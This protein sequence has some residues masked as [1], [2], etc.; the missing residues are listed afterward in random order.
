MA[1]AIATT[2]FGL[3]LGTALRGVD[4]FL[5]IPYADS[6]R[7]FEDPVVWTAPFVNGTRAATS[8]ASICMQP[9]DQSEASWIGSED[10]LFL[11]I[12]RPSNA[13]GLPVMLWIHGGSFLVG[14]GR[15]YNA[16]TLASKH[17]A[18]YVT[19][20]YRLAAFGFAQYAAGHGNYGLKDQ[21]TAMSWVN[22]HIASFGG[23][24]SKV[25]VFGESAGAMSLA[26]H[27]LSPASAGLFAG[28]LMQSG[29]AAA[30]FQ[31]TAVTNAA[32]FAALCG[33]TNQ[34]NRQALRTCLQRAPL[35]V[36]CNASTL[37]SDAGAPLWAPGGAFMWG[38]SVDAAFVPDLPQQMLR[39]G[40]VPIGSTARLIAGVNTD[41]G[42]T[43]T[44]TQLPDAPLD[45]PAYLAILRQI[46][47]NLQASRVDGGPPLPPD[48][49]VVR[50]AVALYPPARGDEPS[51]NRPVLSAL[52]T[53]LTFHCS[54]RHL[55]HALSTFG[56]N[57][58]ENVWLYRFNVRCT[59]PAPLLALPPSCL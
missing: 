48:E 39:K 16:S 7:R 17:Q 44:Y 36:V 1:A 58:S 32:K 23:D 13:S 27:V 5:G 53:D 8:H 24:P 46:I 19:I 12:W 38:P 57:G 4:E 3:L 20:N 30:T 42:A 10:C 47:S 14:G 25:L 59:Q 9:A 40:R 28:A 45:S 22:S 50:Q 33:C 21:R 31:A 52:L 34:S 43:F 54:S 56:R 55:A 49:T 37:A 51:D 29:M 2:R 11:N 35:A 18:V 15:E 6:P 41:E 26:L